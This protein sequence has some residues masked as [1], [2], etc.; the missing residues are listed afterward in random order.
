MQLFMILERPLHGKKDVTWKEGD[1][2]ILKIMCDGVL[3]ATLKGRL[4]TLFELKAYIGGCM[5]V[6]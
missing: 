5:T 1:K 2:I 6:T 3:H 4:P